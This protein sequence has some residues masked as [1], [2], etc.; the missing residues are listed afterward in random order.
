M[1]KSKEQEEKIQ[2]AR[3]L[4]QAKVSDK[5]VR[6]NLVSIVSIKISIASNT[7][8]LFFAFVVQMV[9]TDFFFKLTI[10]KHKN[11]EH[12]GGK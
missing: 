9:K 7:T 5:G 10:Y 4:M 12:N 6:L 2:E 8:C 1:G 11:V 3:R